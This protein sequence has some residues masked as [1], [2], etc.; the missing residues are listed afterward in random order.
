MGSRAKQ[1]H[2]INKEDAES[3]LEL[4]NSTQEISNVHYIIVD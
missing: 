2:N 1:T 3:G 4:T